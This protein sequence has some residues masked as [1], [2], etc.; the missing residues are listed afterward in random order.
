MRID[1]SNAEDILA[2][3]DAV[4]DGLDNVSDR[5]VL[6]GAAK[7]LRIPLIHGALAGLGG[8]LM[9]IFPDDPGMNLLYGGEDVNR[10]KSIS[11]ETILGVPVLMPSLIA[12]FQAME[13]LKIILKRGRVFRNTI[14]YFDL[15]LGEMNEFHLR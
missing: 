9:T 3:S 12:A 15:D 13:V 14:V 1:S 6:E 10:N 8:Q 2:G 4:V 5:P 7:K 11:P